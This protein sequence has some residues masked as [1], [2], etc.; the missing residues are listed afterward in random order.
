VLRARLRP[1]YTDEQPRL[2]PVRFQYGMVFHDQLEILLPTGYELEAGAAPVAVDYAEAAGIK[3]TTALRYS[4]SKAQL[5]N[6]STLTMGLGG[7]TMFPAKAYR[8]LK[9]IFEEVNRAEAHTLV[10]KPK[11]G[12]TPSAAPSASTVPVAD[13]SEDEEA[14]VNAKPAE[15]I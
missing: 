5:V 8:P 2:H 7:K 15:A 14:A 1:R 12:F 10:L 3:Q 4:A 11:P 9:R 6:D 13:G